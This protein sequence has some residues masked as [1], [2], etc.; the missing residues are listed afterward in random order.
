[1]K[2]LM[3]NKKWVKKWKII[4]INKMKILLKNEKLVKKW[5]IIKNKINEKM[6]V[7]EVVVV[8]LD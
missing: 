1:M 5:K 2:K 8:F 4:K 7:Y 3:K 6:K